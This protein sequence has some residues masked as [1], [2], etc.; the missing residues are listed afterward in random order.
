MTTI[1]ICFFLNINFCARID[2]CIHLKRLKSK[3]YLYRILFFLLLHY[4]LNFIIVSKGFCMLLYYFGV[5]T[6]PYN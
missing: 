6:K 4:R 5:E 1:Y 3:Y 2:A